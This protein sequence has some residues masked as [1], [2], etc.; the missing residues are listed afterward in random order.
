MVL[1]I[2]ILRVR[3]NSRQYFLSQTFTLQVLILHLRPQNFPPRPRPP[4][5]LWSVPPF[6]FV[7]SASSKFAPAGLHRLHLLA[8]PRPR[9]KGPPE[10]CPCHI[11]G[12][13]QWLPVLGL[14][15]AS[16][17]VAPAGLDSS[18][19]A[20]AMGPRHQPSLGPLEGL[21]WNRQA[22]STPKIQP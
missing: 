7:F 15:S 9:P 10:S 6:G 19:L 8:S 20:Q 4:W 5:L 12:P 13:G 16:W 21:K 2:E 17:K 3:L 14:A 22:F 18:S 11:F 1:H